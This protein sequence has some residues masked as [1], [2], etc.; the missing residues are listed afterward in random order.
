M[1]RNVKFSNLEKLLQRT[2]RVRECI[3]RVSEDKNLEKL[4]IQHQLWWGLCGFDFC[5]DLP[6]KTLDTARGN[7]RGNFP[8]NN[9]PGGII[10]WSKVKLLKHLVLW[11]PIFPENWIHLQNIFF[12]CKY[13]YITW[14][15]FCR[16]VVTYEGCFPWA[17]YIGISRKKVIITKRY[18]VEILNGC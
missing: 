7:V 11:H 6:K 1:F 14:K 10:P 9:Y 5:T 12:T 2:G 3:F 8:G 4:P 16:P 18:W 15:K 17:I 13:T